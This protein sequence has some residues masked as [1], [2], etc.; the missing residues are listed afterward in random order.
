MDINH[1]VLVGRLTR[2]A[3]LKCTP[4]GKAVLKF[5]IEVNR[6]VRQGDDWKEVPSYFDIALWGR[7]AESLNQYLTKGKPVAID[8]QLR[9]DRWEQD[10]QTRSRVDVMA[11][12]VQLLGSKSDSGG[13]AQSPNTPSKPAERQSGFDEGFTDDIPF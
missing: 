1:V 10:G 2:D 6:R 3:E 4:D 13:T 8:G 12:Y 11:N 5:S 9:Q 7:Q